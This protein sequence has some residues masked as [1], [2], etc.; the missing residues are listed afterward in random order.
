MIFCN[1]LILFSSDIYQ[2]IIWLSDALLLVR[3]RLYIANTQ[4][5]Q[6][7]VH[8]HVGQAEIRLPDTKTDYKFS[9]LNNIL[10]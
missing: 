4:G 1:R 3:P 10:C 2:L 9:F 7:F 5:G 6:V 8:T